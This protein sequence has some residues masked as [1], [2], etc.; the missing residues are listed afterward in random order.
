MQATEHSMGNRRQVGARRAAD[1]SSRSSSPGA[2]T[3]D[4]PL[5]DLVSH[6]KQGDQ[7]AFRE[8]VTATQTGVYNLA[9]QIM[10]NPQE[11]EDMTQE[12]YV[13][14]WR[15]LEG[16]RG[17]SKFTTWLHRVALNA[18]LNRQR[19]LR[20]RLHIVDNDEA[21]ANLP[22]PEIDPAAETIAKQRRTFLW[23]SVARLPQKYRVVITLF[24]QQER[25]YREIAQML[26]LPLGTVKAHLNRARQALAN[27]LRLE[28][29]AGDVYL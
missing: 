23:E 19:K 3:K 9:Y 28:H 4:D 1:A 29:E 20:A 18:C 21:L 2:E 7:A 10:G 15:A 26:S 5:S 11:A 22:A 16:F 12:I 8:L 17:Q 25:S 24:Y 14:V 6:S 27:H 13:R